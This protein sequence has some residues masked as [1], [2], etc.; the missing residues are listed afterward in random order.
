M[1]WYFCESFK[2]LIKVEMEQHSQQLCRFKEIVKKTV[3]IKAKATFKPQ[4]YVCNTNQ[5]Y[6]WDSWPLATKTSNQDQPI[7]DL[8]VDKPKPRP[9]G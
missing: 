3:N 7:K 5:Y 9:K 8:K 2:P 4:S 6:F 1:I